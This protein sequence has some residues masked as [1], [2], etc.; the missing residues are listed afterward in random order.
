MVSQRNGRGIEHESNGVHKRSHLAHN[1]YG[2]DLKN[3]TSRSGYRLTIST[4]NSQK[5]NNERDENK[6]E[7][8]NRPKHKYRIHKRFKPISHWSLALADASRFA[9]EHRREQGTRITYFALI[10]FIWFD[11]A[12][13]FFRPRPVDPSRCS[14][15][16]CCSPVCRY[17]SL[18]LR[19][20]S[21]HCGFS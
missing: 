14:F 15:S 21:R 3:N 2:N 11:L 4:M 9:V 1:V 13:L 18:E 6:N 5:T 10:H 17:F 16:I 19:Y 7:K 20:K 8:Q 12:A